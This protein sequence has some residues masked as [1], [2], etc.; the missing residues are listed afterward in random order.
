MAFVEAREEDDLAILGE[1]LHHVLIMAI[2][3]IIAVGELE[4]ADVGD[5]LQLADPVGQRLV[6]GAQ[7]LDLG[8]WL[9]LSLMAVGEC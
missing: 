6:G 9:F 1:Q 2:I 8:H 5:V 3:D 7:F 4:P